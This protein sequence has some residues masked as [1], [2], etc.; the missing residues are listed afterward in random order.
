MR[1]I[2]MLRLRFRSLLRRKAVEQDL[3]EEFR[4]HLE[5][6]TDEEIAQGKTPEE[7]RYAALRSFANA[8]QRKEE[9]RDRR[10][11]NLIS[12]LARDFRYSMRQL[13]RARGFTAAAII[14]LALGVCAST[15]IFA[16]VDAAL[17][18][19]LPYP[20]PSRLV[21][22]Y[23]HE[24]NFERS[25]L[26]YLDYLDWKKQNKVFTSLEVYRDSGFILSTLPAH[27]RRVRHA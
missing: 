4:Y 24:V 3:D 19:P 8:Q 14:V 16:I 10:R 1:W 9:C 25:N 22:V 26:S 20:D 17:I 2:T 7:A 18:Q 15:A 12:D 21:G 27:S 6:Q 5:R 23:E 13:R 11:L